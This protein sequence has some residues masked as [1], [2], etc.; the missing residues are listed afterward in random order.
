MFKNLSSFILFDAG[1][2]SRYLKS[3]NI[4]LDTPNVNA[5]CLKIV[6]ATDKFKRP[7]VFMD[8]NEKHCSRPLFM[9]GIIK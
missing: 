6:A 2:L 3:S 1:L 9:P 4:I 7:I 5:N 8:K